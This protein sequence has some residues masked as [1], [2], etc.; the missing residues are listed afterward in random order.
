MYHDATFS[1]T[2]AD[3]AKAT[4]HSTTIEAARLARQA[5]VKTLVLGHISLRYKD[6]ESLKT[7]AMQEHDHVLVA[8][9]G[10]VCH[11]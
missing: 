7:E 5:G 10:M 6:L 8:E 2:D 1:M 11:V 4:H 3:R 9:D